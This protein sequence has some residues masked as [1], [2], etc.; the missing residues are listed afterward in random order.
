MVVLFL[1]EC[2]PALTFPYDIDPSDGEVLSSALRLVRGLPLYGNWTEG[3]VFGLY[4]PLYYAYL[5]AITLLGVDPIV[6]GR[7]S[8][9]LFVA[10]SA[11]LAADLVRR[12][13]RSHPYGPFAAF[14]AAWLIFRRA[15]PPMPNLDTTPL[16][17]CVV[18]RG[19]ALSLALAMAAAW[20]VSV[21][22]ERSTGV[23]V[24]AVSAMLTKQQAAVVPAACAVYYAA[25]DRARLRSFLAASICTVAAVAVPLELTTRGEFIRSTFVLPGL[26]FGRETNWP[27]VAA[28]LHAY[29]PSW[30]SLAVIPLALGGAGIALVRG[31]PIRP[32]VF[33]W[34][35]DGLLF[36]KTGQNDGGGNSYLWL[37]WMLTATL[38]GTGAGLLVGDAL[39][40]IRRRRPHRDV[41]VRL[42]MPAA[43]LAGLCGAVLL[44]PWSF[45]RSAMARDREY[46]VELREAGRRHQALIE[47]LTRPYPVRW[48][49]MRLAAPIV[50]AGHVLD[51]EVVTLEYAIAAGVVDEKRLARRFAMGD[52]HFVQRTP[53][54]AS[55]VISPVLDSCYRT[56]TG[57]KTPGIGRIHT[58]EILEY[59]G[60]YGSCAV[61]NEFR[62]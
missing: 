55:R 8:N 39:S 16:L 2:W 43:M 30:R 23:A 62:R 18:L 20:L 45:M 38:A 57:S 28:T 26:T 19:D 61:A 17:W 37:H 13:S 33:L 10:F 5:A 15:S 42:A 24:L 22:P 56:V 12:G 54:L 25:H 52:Y 46:Y 32:L 53:L 34:G 51:Q 21:R 35:L 40:S 36:L 3:D 60:P 48:H 49:A 1:A 29:Y 9:V 50:R 47:T 7:I 58:V 59:V 27:H 6:A 44:T 4:T 11:V 41:L 31:L 14:V